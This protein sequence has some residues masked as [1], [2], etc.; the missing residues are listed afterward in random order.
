MQ[1]LIHEFKKLTDEEKIAFM[2]EAM[3]HMMEVFGKDP[4]KMMSEMM[5]FCMTMMKSKG[6]DME[7]MRTMMKGM[8]E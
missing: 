8:M 5:P 2:K 7:R 3:P 4:Q 1:E 6:M